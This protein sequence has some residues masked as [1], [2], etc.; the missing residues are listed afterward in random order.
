MALRLVRAWLRW[1]CNLAYT[2]HW[3][4]AIDFA[5]KLVA[6]TPTSTLDVRICDLVSSEA[7]NAYA[8][9]ISKTT[10]P[11]GSIPL[12]NGVQDYSSPVNIYSL[13]KGCLVCTSQTPNLYRELDVVQEADIN[14][15]PVSPYSIRSIG[16]QAAVGMLRLE[17]AVAISSG[18]T[19]EIQGEY[20]TNPTKITATTQGMWF[21]D[22]FFDIAVEGLCYWAYKLANKN[23]LAGGTTTQ[24]GRIAYTGKYADF[25]AAIDR[26]KE[27][28]D[29]GGVDGVFPSE[30]LANGRD[31]VYYNLWGVY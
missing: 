27:A 7:W 12:V 3:S 2:Y 10:I 9:Y 1:R 18:E 23:A 26:M 30:N 8:W 31:D 17:A 14:M 4:D 6:G 22:Q 20:K 29:Y 24:G 21:Q 25:R 16:L 11:V 13:T 28:E 15:I 5:T 19:W